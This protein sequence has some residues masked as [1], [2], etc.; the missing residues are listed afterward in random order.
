MKPEEILEKTLKGELSGDALQAEVEK[1]DVAG[2]AEL[3]KL[4]SESAKTSLSEASAL[5]K[6]R[7]RANDLKTQAEKDAG[8]AATK[9]EEAKKAAE[10]G[11][12]K[13]PPAK[14]ETMSQFRKEQKDKAIARIKTELKLTDELSTLVVAHFEKIDSGFVDSDNIY[15]ELLGA[16]AFI[17]SD[18]LLTAD[19]EKRKREEDAEAL[20]AE[21]AGG[22]QGEP[23]GTKPPKYSDQVT[24]LAKEAN[25]TPEAAQK[26]ATEG[27]KRVFE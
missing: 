23:G 3:K 1:L 13:R 6:E 18:S 22:A 26:V 9:A 7:D 15:K 16:Y 8:E 11:G 21:A 4:A 10:T 12:D 27:T 14:D 20:A 24:K 19:A 25:I 2:Q 17:N 5:R